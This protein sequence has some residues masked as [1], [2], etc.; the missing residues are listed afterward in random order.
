MSETLNRSDVASWKLIR[1]DV[2]HSVEED[3][4]QGQRH[5]IGWL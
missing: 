3:E 5:C 1:E 4:V 2:T